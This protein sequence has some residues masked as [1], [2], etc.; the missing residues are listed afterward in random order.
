M[1][2]RDWL[3]DLMPTE[4]PVSVDIKP[5]W[6]RSETPP[7]PRHP[8]LEALLRA[9]AARQRAKARRAARKLLAEHGLA[10]AFERR[11]TCETDS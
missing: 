11:A 1:R 8:R 5:N 10:D 6:F 4:R 7:Q 9:N 2:F 3:S